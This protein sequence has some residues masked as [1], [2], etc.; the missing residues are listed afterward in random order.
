MIDVID[1][2]VLNESAFDLITSLTYTD[3]WSIL[4]TKEYP[5]D[6]SFIHLF[7]PTAL[8]VAVHIGTLNKKTKK[9]ISFIQPPE[10]PNQPFNHNEKSYTNF[11]LYKKEKKIERTRTAT[12]PYINNGKP[13]VVE[14]F[15]HYFS[16][17]QKQ[18]IVSVISKSTE[19]II[20]PKRDLR[21][22]SIRSAHFQNKLGGVLSVKKSDYILV[23]DLAEKERDRCFRDLSNELII[24]AT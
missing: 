15:I 3:D 16:E 19:V 22:S 21:P 10:Y 1:R 12:N 4:L 24:A 7:T 6:I 17:E 9:Y 8:H 14:D 18:K 5:D 11:Y 20:H 23:R 2:E 13:Y